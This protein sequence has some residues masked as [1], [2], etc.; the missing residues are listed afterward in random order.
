M[1]VTCVH[2]QVKPGFAEAFLDASLVNAQATLSEP[3][4]LRF[5][6]L[7]SR[8]DPN[9]FM[10]YEVFMNVEAVEAHKLTPH[11]QHWRD[12]VQPWMEVPR[13][14]VKYKPFFPTD[15]EQWVAIDE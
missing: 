10:F 12:T 6:V 11:Y 7:R 3:G 9:H 13:Q 2:I 5:D 1:Q 4:S 15:P 14:G 8:D